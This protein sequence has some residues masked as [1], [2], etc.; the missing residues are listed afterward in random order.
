[1]RIRALGGLE[2]EGSTLTRPKPLLLLT[3]LALEGPK[4]RGDVAELFWPKSDGRRRTLTVTLGRLRARALGCVASDGRKVWAEVDSDAAQLSAALAHDDVGAALELYRGP[5]VDGYRADGGATEL[6]EWV[7]ATRERIA[8]TL[9]R[10]L[11]ER[12]ARDAVAG[13]LG[14]ARH[15]AE[16]AVRLAAAPIPPAELGDLHALLLAV[17]SA[18]AATI[19]TDGEALGV[20]LPGSRAEALDRLRA[21][22][23]RRPAGTTVPAI[24]VG[25]DR[26]SGSVRF[27]TSV[28]GARVA[29]TT[30]GEGPP[31]VKAA[32]WLSRLDTDPASPVWRHW[33]RDLSQERT[34]VLY[35]QRGNGLSDRDVPVSFEAFVADLET[36]VD[37]LRLDRFDLL[38]MS[39][40]AAASIAFA[41]QHPER[42]RRL[43]LI[44]AYIEP[45]SEDDARLMVELIRTGWGR[46]NPAFRQLFTSLFMP[47]ASAEQMAWFNELQR[48]S[49]TAEQA[50][51]LATAIF[52]IDARPYLRRVRVPT[53]VF[54]A[55]DDAV[56]PFE[57][58][59]RLADA[60]VGARMIALDSKNHVLLEHEPAWQ[61]FLE[62][63]GRFLAAPRVLG[64]EMRPTG[65]TRSRPR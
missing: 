32:T 48:V 15:M 6:E 56:V 22:E 18:D 55:P 13:D 65:R 43:V 53:L 20:G 49:A 62:E 35:D 38:G 17:G 64:G 44:G 57:A 41:A 30:R 21:A 29:Y 51:A 40:G 28:D 52:R 54:H 9:Q 4:A 27:A 23:V 12:A 50:A 1:M 16:R 25:S 8:G 5:F 7:L 63:T 2:L 45:V 11:L 34:L 19:A 60:V 33:L 61:R 37:E 14:E 47:E 26:M 31:L 10:R 42:V 24:V 58:A 36:I 46:D 39:Q 59:Q 3:Y